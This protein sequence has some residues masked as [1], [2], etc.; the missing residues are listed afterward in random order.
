MNDMSNLKIVYFSSTHWDREWYVPFQDFRMSLVDTVDEL[1]EILKSNPDYKVFCL[2]GQTIVLEDYKEIAGERVKEL[3]KLIDDGRVRVGP[4][5][6]MP[7]EFLVSGESLIRNLLFGKKT[8]EKWNTDTMKYGYA[9][10]IFGHIVQMPQI[11]A[12]FGIEGAYLGRGIG[13][14]ER[15]SNFIWT[16]PDG[17]KCY[18][19]AGFYGGFT[20]NV[21]P[22]FGTEK[23]DEELKKYIDNEISK[24][25]APVIFI[26]HT[27]DHIRADKNTPAI[28]AKIKELYPEAEVLHGTPEIIADI[29]KNG[30]YN[31]PEVMGEL[32]K[33]LYDSEDNITLVA[34]SISSYYP[35]KCNN[36]KCEAMLEKQFEPMLVFAKRENKEIDKNFLNKAYDYLLKNQPHDSICGCSCDEVHRDMDYRYNQA[37]EIYAAARVKY[38]NSQGDYMWRDD[39]D[40]VLTLE[41][42]E[43]YRINRVV[44]V[45]IDFDKKFPKT[46]DR[47]SANEPYC[48]FR[49][50]DEDGNEIPYQIDGIKYNVLK[51]LNGQN[52]CL[53]DRY[54]VSF[55]A[56]LTPTSRTYY[57]VAPADVRYYYESDFLIGDDWAE[58]KKIRLDINENGEFKITDKSNGKV[59]DGLNRFIDSGEIGDGWWHMAPHTDKFINSKGFAA[60][61]SKIDSGINKAVFEITK[62]LM[63][64]ECYLDNDNIRSNNLKPVMVISTVELTATSDFVKVHTVIDNCVLDHKTVLKF[65]TG[66][67]DDKYFVS[68]AFCKVERPC[69]VHSDRMQWYEQ[70]MPEKNMG[71]I[72]GKTD[73]NHNGI[74]FVSA[75]GLHECSAE[76]NTD[77]SV[78]VTLLR[79]F[80]RVFMN[81]GSVLSQIQ[82]KLEYDYAFVPMNS[83]KDFADLVNIK[84]EISTGVFAYSRKTQMPETKSASLIAVDNKQIILSILKIAENQNGYIARFYNCSDTEQKANIEINAKKVYEASLNETIL[85]ETECNLTFRPFEIKTLYFGE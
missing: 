51:R 9:N 62:T 78:A 71:G 55:N 22:K 14:E 77:G 65:N 20:R 4:W 8:A 28:I 24:T 17:T 41:N 11:F 53:V 83:N 54:T 35:L 79:C 26:S 7:D 72:V 32:N 49:I 27:S 45:K 64:P 29:V 66:V 16:S 38:I 36:D 6:V 40:Y 74:A 60:S 80:K 19:Y 18:T 61:V 50:Y 68:Q 44:T 21:A 57:K 12:G 81:P 82:G 70:E 73:K 30:N 13:D 59:Y 25:D 85:N 2:D 56:D 63:L 48:C 52:S 46:V 15:F 67:A 23:F 5:Y 47:F 42:Y 1:T 75:F 33:S 43:P 69:G 76:K 34:N 37:K 58:N 10:D 3:Q 39:N 31:I 84:N